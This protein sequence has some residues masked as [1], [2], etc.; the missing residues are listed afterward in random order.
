M[1][2]KVSIG[3]TFK[4]CVNYVMG[5]DGAEVLYAHGVRSESISHAT[6]DFDAVRKQNPGVSNAVWHASISF[7]HQDKVDD[8]L[9]LD[10]ASDYLKQLNLD[11][12]QYLVVKHTD[13]RHQHMH[14]ISNRIGFEGNVVSD[15]WCKNRTARAC[16]L[17]EEKYN[18]T[19]AREQGK[20]LSNDKR[21]DIRQV[22]EEI[23]TAINQSLKSGT[24]DYDL[25]T[26]DLHKK[27][28]DL[29]LQKQS[30]GRINGVTFKKGELI[31]KGSAVGKEFSYKHLL[32]SLEK[33]QSIDRGMSREH[34]R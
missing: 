9:M 26:K 29:Q 1:I 4:G 7:A 6:K 32:Q 8:K 27:G 23:S 11:G 22:K 5:K 2:G 24:S 19:V 20:S 13:T 30:T 18:L 15:R 31:M 10:V 33:N 14:I 34:E 17:M 28:I 25:L 16:D 3:K 12:N 21:G